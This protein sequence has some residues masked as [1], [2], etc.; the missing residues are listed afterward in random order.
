MLRICMARAEEVNASFRR[1]VST[2]IK[3]RTQDAQTLLMMVLIGFG[4]IGL[5]RLENFIEFEYNDGVTRE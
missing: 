4:T 5:V 3:E 2:S 1:L